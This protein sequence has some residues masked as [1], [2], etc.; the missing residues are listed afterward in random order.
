MSSGY[1]WKGFQHAVFGVLCTGLF[2]Q[3]CP[4]L[5]Y[6][7]IVFWLGITVSSSAL[8][9]LPSHIRKPGSFIDW[10]YQF[11]HYPLPDWD[12]L[13]FNMSWHRFFVTHSALFPMLLLVNKKITVQPF[14]PLVIGIVIGLA[15]HLL[16][17]GITGGLSTPI[18][19]IPYLF[20]IAK[21]WAKIWLIANGL[22][23]FLALYFHLHHL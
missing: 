20:S 3:L 1:F 17:D 16:W 4:T 22:L 14:E 23:L 6:K 10:L 8:F 12:I 7:N 9:F 18:V 19:F 2:Y 15:S 21:Y 13:I 5:P 11:L